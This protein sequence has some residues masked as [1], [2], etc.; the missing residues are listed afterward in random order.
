MPNAPGVYITP[1]QSAISAAFVQ[2]SPFNTCYMIVAATTGTAGTIVSV[3]SETEFTTAFGTSPSLKYVQAIF[4][5]YSSIKL[6]CVRA[7]TTA[8]PT[9]AQYA[10]AVNGSFNKD[11]DPGFL[12]AP[13]AFELLTVQG[14]R[15]TV[16]QAIDTVAKSLRWIGLVDTAVASNTAS[17]AGTESDLYRAV[18][19]NTALYWSTGLSAVAAAVALRAMAEF[20]AFE[21]P[22]GKYEIPQSII[23]LLNLRIATFDEQ[24]VTFTPK[25]INVLRRVGGKVLLYSARTLS[26]DNVQGIGQINTLVADN[27]VLRTLDDSYAVFKILNE[28]SADDLAR[29]IAAVMEGLSDTGALWRNATLS[30]GRI[31]PDGYFIDRAVSSAATSSTE[32]LV[33]YALVGTLEQANIRTVRLNAVA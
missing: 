3:A 21:P 5:M 8:T 25:R 17:L 29:S 2:P 31:L 22:A 18:S 1:D 6:R 24:D 9:A 20:G 13:D 16:F 11:L 4:A 19:R 7:G 28:T 14:D 27:V 10:A 23:T 32:L 30:D 33:A 12:I 26:N 15:T